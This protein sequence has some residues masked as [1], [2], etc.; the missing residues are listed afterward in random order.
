MFRYRSQLRR[1]AAH[2]LLLWLFGLGTGF[3]NACIATVAGGTDADHREAAVTKH[4]AH[5]MQFHAG[6]GHAD[7]AAKANCQDFCDK[8]T[9]SLPPLKLAL[10]HADADAVQ[11][12]AVAALCVVSV[13]EPAAQWVPRKDDGLAPPITIAFLRLAL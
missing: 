10:D 4:L 11:L 8:S 3:A 1:W 13:S 7:G 12:P 2:V 6:A 5:A 9:I